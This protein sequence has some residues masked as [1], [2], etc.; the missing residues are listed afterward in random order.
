MGAAFSIAIWILFAAALAARFVVM[1]SSQA[2]RGL[3]A[4]AFWM[5]LSCL[6]RTPSLQATVSS[7]TGGLLSKDAVLQAGECVTL[8]AAGSIFIATL[9]WAGATESK[10]LQTMVIVGSAAAATITFFLCMFARGSNPAMEGAPGWEAV[11]Y[12]L[13]PGVT[14]A[15]LAVHDTPIYFFAGSIIFICVQ[16]LRRRCPMRVV[17]VCGA[18]LT[19]AVCSL[20]QS[21]LID[22]AAL[23]A[24]Q[25]QHHVFIDVLG[26]VSP[27]T[28]ALYAYLLGIVIAVPVASL[29]MERAGLDRFSF[30]RRR[31]SP[32]WRDLTEACPEITQLR[33]LDHLPR[34][35]RY[36]L[37]R[38]V[39]EIR[40]SILILSRYATRA[41]ESLVQQL[42]DVPTERL[43]LRLA[44][45]WRAKSL[46]HPPTGTVAAQRSAAKDLLEETHELIE[47]SR[48]WHPAKKRVAGLQFKTSIVDA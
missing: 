22:V 46:G 15:V 14:V 30:L 38:T 43:A 40:D 42:S 29:V 19:L 47:L 41:D 13:H 33:Q 7:W 12:S 31:L 23:L 44:L 28:A 36:A 9:H 35:P 26:A 34:H 21:V 4:A 20:L 17:A 39:V 48:R 16:E 10:H 1:N 24:M 32:L 27:Y 5:M 6:L 2:D 18:L 8:L 11:A 45:A 25:G 3:N 37:H